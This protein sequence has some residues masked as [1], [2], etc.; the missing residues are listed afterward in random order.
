MARSNSVTG[1]Q[2]EITRYA[3]LKDR[4]YLIVLVL[5]SSSCRMQR[6]S[7]HAPLDPCPIRYIGHTTVYNFY[8]YGK[9][10]E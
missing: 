3:R 5:E 2:V 7:T 10:T 9:L 1:H 8:R 6:D 4:L